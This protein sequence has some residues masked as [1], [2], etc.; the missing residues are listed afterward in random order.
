MKI[1]GNLSRLNSF[2]HE[3]KQLR[4]YGDMNCYSLANELK[5][6]SIGSPDTSNSI[7]EDFSEPATWINGKNKL[8]SNIEE[9][10]NF[11]TIHFHINND[12]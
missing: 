6:L 11:A 2:L 9:H 1:T 3:V 4:G 10:I 12:A 5:S 8:I 7:I